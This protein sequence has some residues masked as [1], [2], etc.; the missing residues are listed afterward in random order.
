MKTS[1]WFLGALLLG[2]LLTLEGC[3]AGTYQ[4]PNVEPVV[5]PKP[6]DDLL[7]NIE[8]NDKPAASSEP[9]PSGAG[10]QKA[11]DSEPSSSEPEGAKPSEP[12]GSKPAKP[13]GKSGSGK[14]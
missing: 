7:S 2:S 8:G 14:K 6:E 10:G 9:E 11:T 3:G 4:I 13:S 1:C 5:K 12:E